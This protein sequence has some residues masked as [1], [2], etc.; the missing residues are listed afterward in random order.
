MIIVWSK[1]EQELVK[2]LRDLK[3]LGSADTVSGLTAETVALK[4]Q[5]ST[6]EIDKSKRE[7]ANAR[8][9]R[10]L[11]HMIGLERERQKVETTQA[12]K[13]AELGVR[14]QNLTADR[15]R[16][17]EQLTFNTQRFEKMEEYLKSMLGQ[18]LERLPN[19]TAALKVGR[20]R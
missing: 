15:K 3:V 5:I 7:E 11:R 2:R 19:V 17:D 20:G 10:E 8:Q 1:D 12:K 14:E 13:E 6:L 9:E 4:T 16:F 18:V